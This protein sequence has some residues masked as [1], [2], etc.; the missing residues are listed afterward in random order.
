[1]LPES[2][3]NAALTQL[4][5]AELIFQRGIPPDAIYQ[6]KHALVQDAAYD[7]L[8]KA[9]KLELHGKIARV[10]EEHFSAA[11][12]PS[13][14]AYHYA[15]ADIPERASFYWLAAG[16]A[17]FNKFAL[18]EAVRQLRLGL[19]EI[20]CLPPGAEKDRRELYT[21]LCLGNVFIQAKGLKSPEVDQAF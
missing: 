19:K 4:V 5:N 1:A 9:R 17:S 11:T 3:L 10:M 14:L 20:D 12:E 7:T 18:T 16:R 21:Q 15:Q 6:F 13:V 2:K 8:L